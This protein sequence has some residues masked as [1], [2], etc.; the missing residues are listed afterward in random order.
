MERTYVERHGFGRVGRIPTPTPFPVGDINSYVLLPPAGSDELVLV[1]TGVRTERAWGA[2]CAGLK[3]FGFAPRDVKLLLLTHAHPDHYGQARRI[4]EESGCR[5]YIHEDARGS[6]E[7]YERMT[8]ERAARVAFHYARWGVPAGMGL[9]RSRPEGVEQWVEP[10]EP[11][12][13][14][15][16]GDT[17]RC[18][19]LDVSVVHTPGH[20]PEEVVFWIPGLR[21]LLS[22]DHLLPDITPIALVDI[23][24][25][26]EARRAPTLVR[27]LESLEKVERLPARRV[28]PS[29]GDVILDHRQLIASYRLH[30]E[31]RK[32]QIARLLREGDLSPAQIGERVFRRVWPEQVHLVLSEVIGH[33]DLLERDGHVESRERDGVI[34][35]SLVSG[36]PPA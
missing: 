34:R 25:A 19:D 22:G 16:D 24:E 2:L 26:P 23:P 14:L 6:F 4:Q 33:L 18:A 9:A 5:I 21:V 29:H 8:P 13:Y 11:D 10:I 36:P 31:K 35:Y 12:R 28:F 15:R 7:R 1:D 30:H 27:F 3:E 32:L 20:C 17:I